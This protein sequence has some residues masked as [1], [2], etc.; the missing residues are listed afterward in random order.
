ML[1]FCSP[2]S[3]GGGTYCSIAPD[4]VVGS[5]C[6]CVKNTVRL[7]HL[8]RCKVVFKFVG[9]HDCP[10][11]LLSFLFFYKY[12]GH[13]VVRCHRRLFKLKCR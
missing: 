13:F 1:G 9:L 2:A 3:S 11:E 6:E 10:L 8:R 4:L 5:V 12:A 7:T